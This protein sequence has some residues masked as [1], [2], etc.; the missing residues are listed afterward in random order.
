MS[1][2]SSCAC[3]HCFNKDVRISMCVLFA[4][5]NLRT[6]ADGFVCGGSRLR[7]GSV[8]VCMSRG[9]GSSIFVRVMMLVS[10]SASRANTAL[11][12]VNRDVGIQI[13]I[14]LG[15]TCTR[16]PIAFGNAFDLMFP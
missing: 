11:H 4:T 1:R 7:N 14:F 6:R 12:F 10:G 3:M 9:D 2:R 13:P 8:S 15:I 5:S 16:V